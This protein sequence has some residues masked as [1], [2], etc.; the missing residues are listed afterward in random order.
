MPTRVKAPGSWSVVSTGVAH[1]CAIRTDGSLWC[2]GDNTHGQATEGPQRELL[3]A[4]RLAGEQSWSRVS[5]GT[6]FSCGIAEQGAL[7]CWGANTSGQLG[8]GTMRTRATRVRVGAAE[9]P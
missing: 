5:A 8:D 9:T 6:L 7:W 4:Q 3:V 1:S 2:W